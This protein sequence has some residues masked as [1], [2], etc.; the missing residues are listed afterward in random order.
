MFP[1]A[2]TTGVASHVTPSAAVYVRTPLRAFR[3]LLRF[4]QA[5][6]PQSAATP[7]GIPRHH[8]PTVVQ[9]SALFTL[10][11]VCLSSSVFPASR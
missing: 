1:G 6:D 5:D 9:R 7:S 8:L 2:V 4:L 11:C 10:Q 3:H